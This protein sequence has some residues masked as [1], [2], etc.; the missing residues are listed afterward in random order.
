MAEAYREYAE[1]SAEDEHFTT[2]GKQKKVAKQ[3]AKMH[4]R[5]LKKVA[6]YGIEELDEDPE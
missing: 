6:E 4:N 2:P 1:G 3:L 5:L